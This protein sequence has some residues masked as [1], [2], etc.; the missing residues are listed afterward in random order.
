MR[1]EIEHKLS[2]LPSSPG[3]YLMKDAAGEVFYIGKARSLRDRVRSYFSGSDTRAFVSRLDRLLADI[4]VILTAT[5]NEA[6]ILENDLIKRHQ[7]R[8]NVMLVDDKS[9]LRLRLDVRQDYPR[10]TV[11]RRLQNDGARYFGPYASATALRETLR[12]VN[13]HFQLRTCSDA[14]MRQRSR[15]CLQ[16]QIG[17]CPAPCVFDLSSGA[18]AAN[19]TA[20]VAFLEGRGEELVSSLT[21]RMSA[22]ADRL[23]FEGAAQVRDQIRAVQRSLERQLVTSPTS[24]S[25]DVVGIYRQR[26]AVEINIL[27][28][29]E[30]RMI[31]SRRFSF[32]DIDLATT[33]VL[34]DFAT[35]YYGEPTQTVPQEI[36]FPEA[37]EWAAPLEAFLRERRQAIV[38]VLVP[39]RGDKRRLVELATRNAHQA[40]LDKA[41]EHGAA[42]TAV[43]RLK[44]R[45]RLKNLPAQ[46]ECFD[47]SHLGGTG[48]VASSVRFANGLP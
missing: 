6:L 16:Y 20:V 34:S 18:Y 22:L 15:P 21:G 2:V 28:T 36:L 41:R 17:R 48:I 1:P 33:D 25:R 44:Q 7:P 47:I 29:R 39:Q 38:E 14:M 19:V 5:D 27:L 32:S 12:L 45:L 30:G 46:M 31:D 24:I 10:L 35:R 40:F 13:R 37:M 23:E 9:F 26:P 4:E 43:E 42:A 11:V 3:V 8:F